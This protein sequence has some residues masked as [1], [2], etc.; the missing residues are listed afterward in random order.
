MGLA[1]AVL[2]A[3]HRV[4]RTRRSRLNATYEL[5][6]A[7]R[8]GDVPAVRGALERGADVKSCSY[9]R[10]GFCTPLELANDT[11]NQEVIALLVSHGRRR[12]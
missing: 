10:N 8:R 11:G 9:D 3:F 7:I 6:E 5:G 12:S 4:F 2:R 1:R